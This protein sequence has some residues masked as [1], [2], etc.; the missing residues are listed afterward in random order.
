MNMYMNLLNINLALARLMGFWGKRVCCHL[1]L[2]GRVDIEIT[3]P[4]SNPNGL[5]D[6]IY[7][8]VLFDPWIDKDRNEISGGSK[9]GDNE[10][11]WKDAFGTTFCFSILFV[12]ILL[13]SVVVFVFPMDPLLG[14]NSGMKRF[15]SPKGWGRSNRVSNDKGSINT[16]SFFHA[17]PYMQKTYLSKDGSAGHMYDQLALETKWQDYWYEKKIYHYDR[18]DIE[19]FDFGR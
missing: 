7:R 12:L 6:S 15:R 9:S 3:H 18:L 10:N 1:E 2:C 16:P 4:N 5:G 19:T 8:D 17:P 13:L 14:G 11:G